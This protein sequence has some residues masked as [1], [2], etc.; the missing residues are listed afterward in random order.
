MLDLLGGFTELLRETL[1]SPWLWVLV[2]V[3]SA[4][5]ALLPFMPS[6]GTVMTVAVLLGPDWPSLGLLVAIAATGAFAGDLG[7][8]WLARGAGPRALRRFEADDRRRRQLE[9]VR[10]RVHRHGPVLAIVGRY[11][12]GGRVATGLACGSLHYPAG[13]FALF[14]AI[15][16]TIWAVYAVA[17][18]YLG[19][20]QFAGEPLKGLLFAFAVGFVVVGIAEITR[21]ISSRTRT[22]SDPD[23]KPRVSANR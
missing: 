9:W 10:Q 5:D 16:V 6:E 17:V 21:R 8:Y 20:S 22:P 14:D 1:D 2:F 4:L 11:V 23:R 18:G 7:G 15:G 19:A 12:P 13:K 3:V